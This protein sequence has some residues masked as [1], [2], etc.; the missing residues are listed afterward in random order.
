MIQCRP[1]LGNCLHTEGASRRRN[2]LAAER[3][4]QAGTRC[5]TR[6]AIHSRIAR[7]V[8]VLTDG[9]PEFSGLGAIDG[10]TEPRTHR[11]TDRRAKSLIDGHID[12]GSEGG[13]EPRGHPGIDSPL[14]ISIGR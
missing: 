2:Q 6:C 1:E 4:S 10:R 13:L 8:E 9:D 5:A 14:G 3:A 7:G 11:A 12:G